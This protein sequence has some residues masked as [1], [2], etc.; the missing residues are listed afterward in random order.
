MAD[1]DDGCKTRNKLNTTEM[2]TSKW[3]ILC[4]LKY[5]LIF[6]ML[7]KISPRSQE[8]Q[9]LLPGPII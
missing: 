7:L 6:K 3:R 1:S 4:Y 2:Y 5:I 8:S 9:I